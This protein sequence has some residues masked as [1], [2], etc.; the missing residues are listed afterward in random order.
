MLMFILY[1]AFVAL[2]INIILG[3]FMFVFFHNGRELFG[4]LFVEDKDAVVNTFEKKEEGRSSLGG[5]E[6]IGMR[7]TSEIRSRSGSER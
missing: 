3:Y 5:I 6:E 7:K 1:H 2:I 4:K